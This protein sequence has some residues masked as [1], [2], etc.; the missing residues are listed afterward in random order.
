MYESVM[1]EAWALWQS[2]L[3][4]AS[5]KNGH[6]LQV[7]EFEYWG[8]EWPY[9]FK[10]RDGDVPWVWN[11]YI[12]YSVVVVQA[13]PYPIPGVGP[14]STVGFVPQKWPSPKSEHGKHNIIFNPG[15][16][17]PDHKHWVAQVAH[18]LG[19]SN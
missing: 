3:G 11:S 19:T 15:D 12:G 14:S 16:Y 1:K 10:E 2:K 9:C 4:E 8:N 6:R 13:Y 5:Q 7:K 17:Y 18:E